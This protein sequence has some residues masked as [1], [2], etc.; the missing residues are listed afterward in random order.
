MSSAKVVA[1]SARPRW[2]KRFAADLRSL[3]AW[4]PHPVRTAL[5]GA[6]VLLIV[7]IVAAWLLAPEGF[8]DRGVAESVALAL[9]AL[10]V[11][12][13][14]SLWAFSVI[15]YRHMPLVRVLLRVALTLLLLG[16]ARVAWLMYVLSGISDH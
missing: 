7:C 16:M 5:G 14:V 9:S 11:A 1:D 6:L 4:S 13:A 3:R 2:Y 15:P 8:Q 12:Y 10:S